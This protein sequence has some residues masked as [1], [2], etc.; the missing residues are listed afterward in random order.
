[1][2]QSINIDN[3]TVDNHAIVT[4][5]QHS[6]LKILKHT[7]TVSLTQPIVSS[8][9]SNTRRQ[10]TKLLKSIKLQSKPYCVKLGLILDDA[11]E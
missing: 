11:I 4:T 7:V 8:Y 3:N 10:H 6:L 5:M 1:M 2:A 9:Q